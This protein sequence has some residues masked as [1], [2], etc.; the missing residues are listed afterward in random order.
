[1]RVV[2]GI[3]L[4]LLVGAL[5]FVG[6]YGSRTPYMDQW[7]EI[8]PLLISERTLTPQWLWAQ[9]NEHRLPLA[10]LVEA[11]LVRAA[12]GDFRAGML[13]NVAVLAALAL[14]LPVALAR[15]RG[16][17]VVA[18]AIFPLLFLGWGHCETFLRGDVC[19]NVLTTA[20]ACVLLVI[21]AFTREAPTPSAALAVGLAL[22]LLP[23]CGATGL[24]FV[25]PVA[26][27]LV[28]ATRGGRASR[29]VLGL[30]LVALALTA[31]YFVG[32][33]WPAY[34]PG[35]AGPL[36]ALQTTAEFLA[37]AF[38]TAAHEDWALGAWVIAAVLVL[39]AALLLGA[40]IRS[41]AE[42]PRALGLAAMLVALVLLA[43]EVGVSRSGF[44]PRAGLGARYATLAAPLLAHAYVAWEL[45]APRPL[46]QGGRIVVLA[47][48]VLCVPANMRSARLYGNDRRARSDAFERDLRAGL[49]APTVARLHAPTIYP[50][51][52]GF[53][54]R[55]E[56]LRMAGIEGFRGLIPPADDWTGLR[57]V[58]VAL[59]QGL[60][61]EMTW[62]AGRGQPTGADPFVVFPLGTRRYVYA[63]RLRYA[64]PD[65]AATDTADLELFWRNT[66]KSDFTRGIR[67][68]RRSVPAAPDGGVVTV[69]VLDSLD[70]LRID[71]DPRRGVL[72]VDEISLL[73]ARG[74]G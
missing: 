38:G 40:A 74:S 69:E 29:W 28:V 71:A 25:P 12:A 44:G 37:M 2:V 60:T 7:G 73:V 46:L 24:P 52:F 1:M 31:A 61:H 10:K 18:D 4:L 54:L 3:W 23:L 34:H 66:R 43:L 13:F 39:D 68:V 47:L 65:A 35:P 8:V 45:Y 17:P 42:R 26:V 64:H 36:A 22:V 62:A 14:A 33:E 11:T 5:G 30:A 21:I 16:S 27:W 49:P 70:E 72:R 9:H 53:T 58:P 59:D 51:P 67:N 63:V 20:L 32:L 41:P 57:A 55:L 6:R 56:G 19:G 48:L 15:L 50:D